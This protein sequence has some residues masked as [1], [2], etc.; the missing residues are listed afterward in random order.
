MTLCILGH[1]SLYWN[2]DQYVN[3][4]VKSKA[5]LPLLEKSFVTD[6]STTETVVAEVTCTGKTIV[7]FVTSSPIG[8]RKSAILNPSTGKY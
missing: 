6:E 2:T 8:L 5:T 4:D 7:E 3:I 1:F